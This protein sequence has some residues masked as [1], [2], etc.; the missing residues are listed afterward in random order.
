MTEPSA[1]PCTCHPTERPPI[2]QHRYATRECQDAY[3]AYSASRITVSCLC[4]TK[5]CNA[6]VC[7]PTTF[8]LAITAVEN[9]DLRAALATALSDDSSAPETPPKP[10]GEDTGLYS[11]GY[12][13]N[14]AKLWRA[15]KLIGGNQDEVVFALLREIERL[16]GS[17]EETSTRHNWMCRA[18]T[19]GP[20]TYAE[21]DKHWVSNHA[22]R[23]YH[24]RGTYWSGVPTIDMPC[25]FCHRNFMAHDPR[26]HA[27]PAAPEVSQIVVGDSDFARMQAQ[28]A[29]CA[30][31]GQIDV[32]IPAMG[33]YHLCPPPAVSE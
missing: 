2:C 16:T 3:R 12:A 9:R 20:F 18:C 10:P 27:C 11:A 17:P 29:L 14:I 28:T 7:N 4:G 6:A 26:T 1:R 8:K 30:K 31:C 19:Q 24:A 23:E 32:R 21:L 13:I 15:G 22:R 5:G 33:I 25:D